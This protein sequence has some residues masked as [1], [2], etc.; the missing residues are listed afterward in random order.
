MELRIASDDLRQLELRARRGQKV[1]VF[2]SLGVSLAVAFAM[3]ASA[4]AAHAELGGLSIAAWVAGV[5]AA[6]SFVLAWRRS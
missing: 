4:P 3:L 1:A 6:V 5:A 2:L